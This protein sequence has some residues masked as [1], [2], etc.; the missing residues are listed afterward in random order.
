[1]KRRTWVMA[2]IVG[3]FF[4]GAS[5][6]ED[7]SAPVQHVIKVSGTG[8]VRVK[9]DR[10]T[11]TFGVR[12]FAKELAEAKKLHDAQ[13]SELIAVIK[14][15]KI[16]DSD[17]Q[18]SYVNAS[19]VFE[20]TKYDERRDKLVGYESTSELFVIVKDLK[21]LSEVVSKAVAAGASSIKNV[22]FESSE[23]ITHR[24]ESLRRAVALAR[25]H[26]EIMAAELGQKVGKAIE[27]DFL[28][29][30]SENYGLFGGG[31]FG[32]GR[33]FGDDESGQA[34]EVFAAGEI[35]ISATVNVAFELK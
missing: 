31:G 32:G 28:S 16:A 20:I 30:R 22:S 5:F 10:A 35:E 6:G 7:S 15:L 33:L 19:P 11:V 3:M 17:Y 18:T 13:M 21:I 2:S 14:E 12:A 24:E 27:I 25:K 8:E 29:A 4:C 1:M 23:A 34:Y 26:A 9:P